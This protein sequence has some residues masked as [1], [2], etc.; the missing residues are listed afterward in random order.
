MTPQTPPDDPRELKVTLVDTQEYQDALRQL[1][2]PDGLPFT[3]RR[4]AS[5]QLAQARLD[6]LE[7]LYTNDSNDIDNYDERARQTV[8]V[9]T[10]LDAD[11]PTVTPIILTAISI[12]GNRDQYTGVI[13]PDY[14]IQLD[15]VDTDG[16]PVVTASMGN[17][18]ARELI[19]DMSTA[20]HLAD[21]VITADTNTTQ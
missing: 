19:T 18:A 13:A 16:D 21:R 5:K 6:S 20:L 8:T 10:D 14:R 9:T 1:R 2:H 3:R 12:F 4:A 11:T 17:D 15:Y 7:D